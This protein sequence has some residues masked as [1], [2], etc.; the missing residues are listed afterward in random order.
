MPSQPFFG[1][2]DT[3]HRVLW[4]LACVCALVCLAAR[5]C[6][7]E[8]VCVLVC[9]PRVLEGVH[10]LAREPQRLDDVGDEACASLACA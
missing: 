10:V 5:V 3:V 6:L 4:L 7:Q 9:E 2:K 1:G 8:C